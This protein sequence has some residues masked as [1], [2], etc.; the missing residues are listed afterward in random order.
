MI[1]MMKTMILVSIMK[2]MMM[3]MVRR[4]MMITIG[5]DYIYENS[6][7]K[8]VEI[9]SITMIFISIMIYTITVT[10]LFNQS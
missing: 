4:M 5:I 1:V 2:V 6:Q 9:V 10:S 8:Y 7:G 3:I